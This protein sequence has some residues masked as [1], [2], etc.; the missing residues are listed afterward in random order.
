MS[1]FAEDIHVEFI[2][3]FNHSFFVA[4]VGNT[5]SSPKTQSIALGRRG[6]KVP[7]IT[8]VLEL[9]APRV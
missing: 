1:S 3:V 4:L 6:K 5:I 7:A 8:N 2:H 9:A